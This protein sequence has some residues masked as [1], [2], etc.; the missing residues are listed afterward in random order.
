MVDFAFIGERKD[1]GDPD[2]SRKHSHAQ[3]T[4]Q[5]FTLENHFSGVRSMD[6]Q[7]AE[8][9]YANVRRIIPDHSIAYCYLLPTSD[10]PQNFATSRVP[11]RNHQ[12]IFQY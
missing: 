1:R 2:R 12:S 3:K 8:Q 7:P 6:L 4:F 11:N 9:V 5:P 10:Q